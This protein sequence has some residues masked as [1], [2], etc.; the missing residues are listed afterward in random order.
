M[1]DLN[2]IKDLPI[3]DHNNEKLKEI[4][5]PVTEWFQNFKKSYDIR[6]DITTELTPKSEMFHK[7]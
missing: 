6:S 5:E 4:M 1:S 3:I 2:F 7:D